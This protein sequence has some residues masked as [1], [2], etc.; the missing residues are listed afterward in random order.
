MRQMSPDFVPRDSIPY[1]FY[2]HNDL[3]NAPYS[4][5][6]VVSQLRDFYA[7]N[8]PSKLSDLPI[9]IE[10]WKQDNSGRPLNDMLTDIEKIYAA[11]RYKDDSEA[12]VVAQLNEFYAVNNPSKLQ[13][14][15]MI[16]DK[17]KRENPSRPLWD[18]LEDVAL[19]YRD[20]VARPNGS[21][22]RHSN[23]S[24]ASSV[25]G[26][27]HR[28]SDD[29]GQHQQRLSQQSRRTANEHLQNALFRE[30]VSASQNHGGHGQGHGQHS[31]LHPARLSG[32]GYAHSP[33][34]PQPYHHDQRHY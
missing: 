7:V 10:G 13:S 6:C 33:A 11:R 34:P 32:S 24:F 1:A 15:Y 17:W 31:S 8:N 18:I 23:G 26:Q 19:A 5:A 29:E 27:T 4:E 25:G 22:W 3:D 12:L 30:S 2:P 20:R 14:L 28:S 21:Q 9:L 16:L